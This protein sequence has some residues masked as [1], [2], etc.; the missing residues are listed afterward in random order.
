[1]PKKDA[2]AL[3]LKPEATLGAFAK[4][5][6][7][8]RWIPVGKL[9]VKWRDAQRMERI[10]THAKR[11]ASQFDPDKFGILTITLPDEKGIH[12]VVDG[13]H[14]RTA[15]ELL[16]G[17][18]EKV[19]CQILPTKDPVRAAEIFLAMNQGRRQVSPVDNFRAS[20]R[21]GHPDS[22]NINKVVTGLGFKIDSNKVQGH[23]ACVGALK[24]V[25]L[26]YG[27]EVLHDALGIVQ[28]TWGNNPYAVNRAIIVAFGR[29]VGE[30]YR[31]LNYGRV[32]EVMQKRFSS[33][34]KL[35]ALVGGLR[36]LSGGSAAEVI[37][38]TVID[39]YNK[40]LKPGQL[41]S[42]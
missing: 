33:P 9:Q 31:T 27:P 42:A 30:N 2:V 35:L 12:H 8:I 10:M 36:E 15:V 21:A 16:W 7:N 17:G 34:E 14:R 25:Y 13:D 19:P 4:E 38:K 23:I 22:V 26:R 40:G 41:L 28:A 1:M 18:G 6:I 20:V 29:L 24:T 3:V 37:F 39:N 32:K 11:I 5:D